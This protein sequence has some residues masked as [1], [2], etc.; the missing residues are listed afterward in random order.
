MKA[1]Q[2]VAVLLALAGTGLTTVTAVV[3]C[4]GMGANATEAQLRSIEAWAW[5]LSLMGAAGMA[6]G[7]TLLR[8]GRPGWAVGIAVAPCFVFLSIL[9]VA[10]SR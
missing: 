10:L 9:V 2:V 7:I 8:L 5:G 6:G 1:L 3:F 4:L